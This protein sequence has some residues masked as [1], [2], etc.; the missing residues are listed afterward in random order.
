MRL[1]SI[2]LPSPPLPALLLKKY[3]PVLQLK[4]PFGGIPRDPSGIPKDSLGI[5]G[6]FGLPLRR[7][8]RESVV[9]PFLRREVGV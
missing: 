7:Q 5:I 6:K 8:G 2:P 3:N 9:D 4:S 1:K